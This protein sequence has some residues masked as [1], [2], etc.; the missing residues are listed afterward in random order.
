MEGTMMNDAPAF[1]LAVFA[2]FVV[3]GIVGLAY[4]I[5]ESRKNIATLRELHTGQHRFLEFDT[6]AHPDA[7]KPEAEQGAV[8]RRV[9]SVSDHLEL[10]RYGP[11]IIKKAAV[12]VVMFAVF[13]FQLSRMLITDGSLV[14]MLLSA[15]LVAAFAS[16]LSTHLTRNMVE[17]EELRL[18][19]QAQV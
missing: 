18:R 11:A 16:L 19:G 3:A 14:M 9:A 17:A 13:A 5:R 8:D 12:G 4:G 1:I 10:G 2:V 15:L 7:L 6:K